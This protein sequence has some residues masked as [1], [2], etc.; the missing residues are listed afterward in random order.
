VLP[1]R[2]V[3]DLIGGPWA[4]LR[5]DDLVKN[6]FYL[7][8]ATATQGILGMAFWLLCARLFPAAQVGEATALISA[9]VL[10]AYLSLLGWNNSLIRYLPKA[11]H[12]R[13]WIS[14]GLV[15]CSGFSILLA[16]GYVLLLPS[17]TGQLAFVRH[18]LLDGIGF[19]AFASMTALVLLT[20]AIFIARRQAKYNLLVDGVVQGGTKLVLLLVLASAGAFGIFAATGLAAGID[21]LV[22]L[23]L[24]V[25]ILGYRLSLRTNVGLIRQAMGFSL[26]NYLA[27]LLSL[28]PTLILPIVVIDEL[29]PRPAAYYYIAFSIANLLNAIAYSTCQS[30]F[31]EGSHGDTERRVLVRRSAL[32]LAGVTV[33][34]AL[35]VAALAPAVLSLFGRPYSQHASATLVVLALGLM[36]VAACAWS[37]TLLRITGQLPSLIAASAAYAATI[38]ALATWWARSGLVFVAL[39]WVIGNVIAA[40]IAGTSLWQHRGLLG[41][42]PA[43]HAVDRR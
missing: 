20:D 21:V 8:A 39:A 34:A 13:D 11:Q 10:L 23:V 24:I 4:R 1:S 17:I 28:A 43:R 29:G 9:S 5:N 30:L 27:N 6:S 31:V 15:L 19:V 41:W 38:C 36:P 42:R 33:P 16:T 12:P 25:W 14:S 32:L 3:R 7:L 26:A 22:S 2:G 40:A 18:S 35:L 37:A